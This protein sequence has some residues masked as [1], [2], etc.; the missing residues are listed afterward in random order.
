MTSLVIKNL[1]SGICGNV[2]ILLTTDLLLEPDIVTG[3]CRNGT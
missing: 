3:I 1:V 2:F